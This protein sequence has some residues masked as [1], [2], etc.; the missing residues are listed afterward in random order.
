MTNT[1]L[2]SGFINNHVVAKTGNN[3]LLS[4]PKTVLP[5]LHHNHNHY[6]HIVLTTITRMSAQTVWIMVVVAVAMTCDVFAAG[7][8]CRHIQ[9]KIVH[10]LSFYSLPYYF[11][12][13]HHGHL[14][15]PSLPSIPLS[16]ECCANFYLKVPSLCMYVLSL[17]CPIMTGW[18]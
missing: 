2:R 17:S 10:T 1:P 9:P 13:T 11:A 12:K 14:L 7:G 16:Q 3:D 8:C 18:A 4:N 15:T 5:S 6:Q